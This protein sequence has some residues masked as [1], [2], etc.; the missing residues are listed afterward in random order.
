M[1]YSL[2]NCLIDA[3]KYETKRDWLNASPHLV[4]AAGR[5]KWYTEC[6]EHMK[7][8]KIGTPRKWTLEKCRYSAQS[9]TNVTEWSG[10][11]AA[12]YTAAKRYGW[13]E[14]VTKHFKPLGNTFRRL[15]YICRIRGTKYVYIGLTINF[16]KRKYVHMQSVRFT[17]L[18]RNFGKNSVRFFKVTDFIDA[19]K[20][21]LIENSLI[22]K[23]RTRGFVLLNRKRGGG[24]GASATKWTYENVEIDA[25]QYSYVGEWS[26]K[27]HA[28]YTMALEKGWLDQLVEKGIIKRKVQKKGYWTKRRIIKTAKSCTSRKEW[29]FK[30]RVAYDAAVALGLHND[31]DVVGHF[32]SPFKWLGRDD[33]IKAEIKKY[34]TLK[35]FREGSSSLYSALK[36][37]GRL[38]E[39]SSRLERARRTSPWTYD[40]ILEE[41]KKYTNKTAFQKDG[42]GAYTA[43][44]RLECFDQVTKHMRRPKNYDAKTNP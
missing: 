41:A 4:S 9:F 43:A 19:E 2:E 5:H 1:K 38:G 17:E 40:E 25:M 31:L 29:S 26:L 18:V 34:K 44:K 36:R 16:K 8:A 6:T 37:N 23:Y 22:K 39:F 14:E 32:E 13:L 20:A 27:S 28:A 24:L 3:R 42:K 12:A 7:P 35:E 30:Y 10:F 11:D 33:A 21:A 15:V